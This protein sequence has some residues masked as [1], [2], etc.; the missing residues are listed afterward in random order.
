M[1]CNCLCR[2]LAPKV[3]IM[4]SLGLKY[5]CFLR[6]LTPQPNKKVPA[7][8]QKVTDLDFVKPPSEGVL[9]NAKLC[10]VVVLRRMACSVQERAEEPLISELVWKKGRDPHP[11]D[12]IQHLDFTMDAQ[13]LYYKTPPCVFYHKNVRSKAVF[14]P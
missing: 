2:I 14:G 9:S 4:R 13:P 6:S 5:T 8:P 7:S 3:C 12:K 10:C 1:S 11:Q